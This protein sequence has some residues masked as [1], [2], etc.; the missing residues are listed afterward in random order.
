MKL[1]KKNKW[2]YFSKIYKYDMNYKPKNLCSLFWSGLF[3]FLL[4]IFSPIVII[5]HFISSKI[6]K[7]SFIKELHYSDNISNIIAGFFIDK[8]IMLVYIMFLILYMSLF[9][10]EETNF[11]NLS[12]Y[13]ILFAPFLILLLFGIIILIGC[14]IFISIKNISEYI[15]DLKNK[16][17]KYN[18]KE[19]SVVIEFIKSKKKKICPLI[20]WEN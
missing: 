1:S 4:S 18:K 13:E 9:H 15:I 11:A 2:L 10:P 12:W 20:Q 8:L 19:P 6:N 14:L 3:G 7:R 17:T 5:I 16:N